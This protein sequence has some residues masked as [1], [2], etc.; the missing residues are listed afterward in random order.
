MGQLVEL[1]RAGCLRCGR[2]GVWQPPFCR[3]LPF[4]GSTMSFQASLLCTHSV[5]KAGLSASLFR[6]CF[7]Q[8][9][10]SLPP[11]PQPLKSFLVPIVLAG[12]GQLGRTLGPAR[13]CFWWFSPPL[14]DPGGLVEQ[15][16]IGLGKVLGQS[17]SWPAVTSNPSN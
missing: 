9:G 5:L 15:T 7:A 13:P 10:V 16:S 3:G 17:V 14:S 1:D 4:L 8:P 2:Q 11:T 12:A 6:P